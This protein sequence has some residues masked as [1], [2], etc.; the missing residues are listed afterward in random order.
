M[1]IIVAESAGYCYGVKRAVEI[2]DEVLNRYQGKRIYSLGEIIHNPQ[3][4]ERFKKKGLIVVS[5]IGEVQDNSMVIVS[6]H[7]RSEWD[8]KMLKERGC[9]IVDATCPYVIFPQRVIERLTD[10]GYFILLFGDK[11]H[12]EV[13]GLI[14]YSNGDKISVINKDVKNFDF[15]NSEKVG[16]VA[17]T[18]QNKED[19][20][21]I[22]NDISMLFKEV[23]IFNT[24]CDATHIRQDEAI[25]ISKESDIMVVVGGRN[26]ANTRRLYELSKRYCKKVIYIETADEINRDDFGGVNKIGVTAGASTPDDIIKMVIEKIKSF[27]SD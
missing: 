21:R 24:I 25:R 26:S 16:L 12:P 27:F 23:R 7:G 10:E 17:Q 4:V 6:A 3:V 14:S 11:N 8:L 2:T 13:K 18:T 9:Q 19:F 20:L 5:E 22:I 15:V 1:E